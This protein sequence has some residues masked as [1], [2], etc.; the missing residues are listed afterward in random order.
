ME[1]DLLLIKGGPRKNGATGRMLE[2]L[3]R[4]AEEKGLNC[5]R[6][7]LYEK[8]LAPCTG[9][10]SCRS[11]GVCVIRDDLAELRELINRS[12]LIALAAPTYFA[13]VPG[14]V[15]NMFDRLSGVILDEK[16]RHKLQKG[17]YYL[18]LTSCSTPAPWDRLTG[19]SAGTIRAMK[20]FFRM[21]GMTCRGKVIYSGAKDQADLPK[22]IKNKIRRLLL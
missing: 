9:C 17:K 4:Y 14:P 2:A 8:T 15:K 20:E 6:F 5:H 12:K 22:H 11:T 13:N 19:Q 3:G 1:K 18:L 21:G 7:D 10:R 16:A